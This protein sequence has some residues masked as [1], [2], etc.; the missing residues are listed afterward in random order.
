MEQIPVTITVRG[1]QRQGG[2]IACDPPWH[3]EF[4]EI[5][6][7]LS[8]Q[9]HIC[10]SEDWHPQ[11]GCLIS[12]YAD[13]RKIAVY[14][15][16]TL[17]DKKTVEDFLTY[18]HQYHSSYLQILVAVREGRQKDGN[19]WWF[20]EECDLNT[21]QKRKDLSDCELIDMAH[22]QY[23]EGLIPRV[24]LHIDLGIEICASEDVEMCEHDTFAGACGAAGIYDGG[25]VILLGFILV[26]NP[27]LYLGVDDADSRGECEMLLILY[28]DV[29]RNMEEVLD[30]EKL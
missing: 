7:I 3:V 12:S 4:A 14:C 15:A 23:G 9:A 10:P 22:R 25:K 24:D 20:P 2:E 1:E 27:L 13:G 17:P 26:E 28:H 5:Y 6:N 18:I 8:N 29:L 30:P 21:L 16:E 19:R 11:A